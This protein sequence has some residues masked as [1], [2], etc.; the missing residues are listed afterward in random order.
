M[1]QVTMQEVEKNVLQLIQQ[2]IAGEEIVVLSN[3]LPVVKF[4]AIKA[5]N[6][7]RK[8]RVPGSAKGLIHMADD[9]DDPLE[10]FAEYM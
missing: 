3:N 4:S 10:D 2:A 8:P 6:G 5:L 9:F 7:E 1:I